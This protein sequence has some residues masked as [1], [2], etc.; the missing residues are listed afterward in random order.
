MKID[1]GNSGL[2]TSF[3]AMLTILLYGT[4]LLYTYLKIDVLINKKD[5]DIMSTTMIANISNDFIVSYDLTG[6]NLAIAFT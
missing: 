6:L 4:I 1:K 2:N 3:G 5:V